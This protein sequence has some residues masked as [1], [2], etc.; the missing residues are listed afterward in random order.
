M[1]GGGVGGGAAFDEADEM[2]DPWQ[3]RIFRGKA[4]L[5]FFRG[6][7]MNYVSWLHNFRPQPTQLSPL[8][9]ID[10]CNLLSL[11]AFL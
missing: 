4:M 1:H 3:V 9:R 11:M 5:V 10:R 8:Q 6:P 7:A 2:R